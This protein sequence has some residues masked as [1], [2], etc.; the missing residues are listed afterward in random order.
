MFGKCWIIIM[1][2]FFD[3]THFLWE[4]KSTMV[5]LVKKTKLWSSAQLG[6]EP[7]LGLLHR[8]VL[9]WFVGDPW[10]QHLLLIRSLDQVTR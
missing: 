2:G 1:G 6:K 7:D 3:N 4:I 8:L 5:K 10:T 9:L